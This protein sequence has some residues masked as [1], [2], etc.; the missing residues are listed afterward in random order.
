MSLHEPILPINMES[1]SPFGVLKMA[2]DLYFE[3]C[4]MG[5]P[6][7]CYIEKRL[8]ADIKQFKY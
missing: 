7:N 2:K 8:N 1:D 5:L 4:N 3:A 6:Q